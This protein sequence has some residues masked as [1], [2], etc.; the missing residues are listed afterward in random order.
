M[1]EAVQVPLTIAGG[2]EDDRIERRTQADLYRKGQHVYLRYSELEE[3]M[4]RTTTTV[5]LG[6][7]GVRIIRHGDVRSEQTFSAGETHRGYYETAHG[8]VELATST[9]ELHMRLEETGGDVQWRYELSVSGDPA[10]MF[11]LRLSYGSNGE[12]QTS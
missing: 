3:E 6:P 2:S 7:D 8:K 9:R 11:T 4:G 12:G 5:R 1:T 10:G